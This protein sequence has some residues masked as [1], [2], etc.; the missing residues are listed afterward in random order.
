VS[1]NRPLPLVKVSLPRLHG[2]QIPTALP[3]LKYLTPLPPEDQARKNQ[4]EGR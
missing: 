3:T 1:R 2:A 4:A